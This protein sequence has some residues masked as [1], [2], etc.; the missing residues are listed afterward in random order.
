MK[1]LLFVH[2]REAYRRNSYLISYMFYKNTL[3]VFPL[4]WFGIFSVF[5]GTSF[6]DSILY[7]LFNI[8]FTSWPIMYF[9]LF[10]FQHPKEDFL[11]N[12]QLY[13]IGL[14]NQCFNKWIFWR[15]IIY[16]ILQ[17]ALALFVCIYTIN[18]VDDL[19]GISST[20]FV[21][22]QLVYL[23]VVV[24]VNIKILTSTSNYTFYSIFFTTCSVL[25][26]V[27]F[28]FIVS[29]FSSANV[30]LF[31]GHV[32]S[33]PLNYFSLFFIGTALVILDSGLHLAQR[34]LEQFV[35][36]QELIQ[37]RRM[38]QVIDKD[39]AIFRRRVTTF[40]RMFI[41]V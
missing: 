40:T 29:Q 10:D 21:D 23:G 38:Q 28:F 7:Q 19:H 18:I 36:L 14:K 20:L 3:F 39:R 4:F 32:F 1:P 31:F 6:Y 33:E 17:G 2:G 15:W 12:H 13:R 25:F 27:V 35:N 9:S 8:V 5:S 24:L 34:E 22:G 41:V 26:F 37:K 11:A 16:A 30:Y